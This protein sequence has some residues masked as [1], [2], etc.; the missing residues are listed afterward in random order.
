MAKIDIGFIALLPWTNVY[1]LF[2]EKVT[3]FNGK[4]GYKIVEN[5]CYV[6]LCGTVTGNI[7]LPSPV[8]T[9]PINY[10][11]GSE[12]LTLNDFNGIIPLSDGDDIYVSLTY[13]I[14]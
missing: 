6:L 1:P 13:D 4:G 11:V 2:D 5:K 7:V 8:T 3:N 14:A 12:S 9:I 10:T